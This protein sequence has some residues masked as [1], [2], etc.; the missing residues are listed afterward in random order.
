MV[1]APF[2]TG[3][4]QI[5]L[6]CCFCEK[7]HDGARPAVGEGQWQDMTLYTV[8]RG[9][10]PQNIIFAYSCCPNC[11]TAWNRADYPD[12]SPYPRGEEREEWPGL[13]TAI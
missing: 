3:M 8:S 11:L 6:I 5:L 12:A 2:A 7:V 10:R 1:V 9:L 4:R 13:K